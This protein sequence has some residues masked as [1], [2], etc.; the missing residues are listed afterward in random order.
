MLIYANLQHG[1]ADVLADKP[2][3]RFNTKILAKRCGLY[4]DVCGILNETAI[5]SLHVYLTIIIIL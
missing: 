1:L 5:N 2:H 4:A 3:P